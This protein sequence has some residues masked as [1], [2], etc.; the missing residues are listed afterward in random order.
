[1]RKVLLILA[2]LIL[3][4]PL[5]GCTEQK[6]IAAPPQDVRIAYIYDEV[7]QVCIWHS[8]SSFGEAIAVLPA[9]D[10]ANPELPPSWFEE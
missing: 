3:C 6:E 7:H 2:L 5:W 4:L 9:K 8:E 1:M 10:V